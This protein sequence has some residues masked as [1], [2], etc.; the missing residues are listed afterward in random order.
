MAFPES[1][2]RDLIDGGVA[3][4]A[5]S[6]RG[7]AGDLFRLAVDGIETGASIVTVVTAPE[8]LRQVVTRARRMLTTGDAGPI[9]ITIEGPS[10]RRT[11]ELDREASDH[12]AADQLAA[13]VDEVGGGPE[14]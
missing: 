2:A 14:S 7:L 9:R 8:I 10:G 1:L 5:R 6:P 3:A 11:L 12:S 13:F 4:P